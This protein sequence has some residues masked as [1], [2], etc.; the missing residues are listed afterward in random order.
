MSLIMGTPPM[1]VEELFEEGTEMEI[2]D[3]IDVNENVPKKVMHE[4]VVFTKAP[5]QEYCEPYMRFSTPCKVEGNQAC[6]AEL[7]M[8]YYDNYMSKNILNTLG[9]VRLD[10]DDYGK[11][12]VKEIRVGVN[13]FLLTIKSQSDFGL[14]AMRIDVTMLKEDKDVDT[15]LVN[16]LED[17]I[18]V[19]IRVTS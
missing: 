19:G 18:E 3:A 11:K 15:L 9:Y 10:Y 16:L 14:G 17:M 12:P 5:Y 4:V 8:A 2:I 13:S 6:D 7:N 1:N